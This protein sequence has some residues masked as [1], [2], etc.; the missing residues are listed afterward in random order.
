MSET[1]DSKTLVGIK[2][3]MWEKYRSAALEEEKE[4]EALAATIKQ[5]TRTVDKPTSKKLLPP[6]LKGVL[7]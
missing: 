7:K 3:S 1:T 5:M 4:Q 6:P 2:R